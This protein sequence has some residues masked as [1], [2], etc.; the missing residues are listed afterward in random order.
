LE[1]KEEKITEKAVLE[2][3][4]HP[5]LPSRKEK[6]KAWPLRSLRNERKRNEKGVL[7][8]TPKE[9]ALS[10]LQGRK[11]QRPGPCVL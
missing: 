5:L 2:S 7:E 8:A 11:K 1:Q 3:D 10:F 4:Y 6:A 9:R